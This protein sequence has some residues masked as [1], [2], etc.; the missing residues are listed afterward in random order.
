MTA[1][2]LKMENLEQ[3]QAERED[4]CQGREK[5]ANHKPKGEVQKVFPQ[6]ELILLIP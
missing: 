1:V 5:M 2:Q 4:T 6:K 3:R